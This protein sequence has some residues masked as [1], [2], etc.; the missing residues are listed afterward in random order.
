MTQ[1]TKQ[2][3]DETSKNYVKII[4]GH[5][6][7]GGTFPATG[8]DGYEYSDFR[9]VRDAS[10]TSLG[11]V[12]RMKIL[13]PSDKGLSKIRDS[14]EANFDWWLKRVEDNDSRIKDLL[15]KEDVSIDYFIQNAL[16]TRFKKN[17]QVEE[18][19]GWSLAQLDGYGTFL[20]VLGKYLNNNLD[21]GKK[22][23]FVNHVKKKI[24]LI[25]D[26]M[27]KFFS[28]P[29]YDMWE[30]SRFFKEKPALHSSTIACVYAGLKV[31]TEL[32]ISNGTVLDKI[33]E[34][35][36]KNFRNENKEIVKYI[37]Q[38]EDGT[39]VM[40]EDDINHIDSSMLLLASPF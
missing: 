6:D 40:P 4:L 36:D 16:P 29:N 27:S 17:G 38:E 24:K 12:E 39:Y 33:N 25:S 32:G 22:E 21:S 23:T 3:L 10:N 1:I 8:Q 37:Q 7:R 15:G 34:F 26:Y 35:V 13:K 19:T 18:N 31:A 20:A 30:D 14:L 5:Q 9:W 28:F 2:L 11:L